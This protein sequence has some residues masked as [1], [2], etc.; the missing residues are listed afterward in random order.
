[1]QWDKAKDS[2]LDFDWRCETSYW[3]F[4]IVKIDKD[5]YAL[6]ATKPLEKLLEISKDINELQYYAFDLNLKYE[7]LKNKEK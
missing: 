4:R 1:M 2:N 7:R 3:S 5:N 6:Y